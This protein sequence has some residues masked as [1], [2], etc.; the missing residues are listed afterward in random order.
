MKSLLARI[1]IC[2]LLVSATTALAASEEAV[3]RN[4]AGAKLTQQGKLDAAIDAFQQAIG[5]DPN[6][7]PARL[8]LAYAYDKANQMDEAIDA[9]R[10]AIET[11]PRSFFAH[12]NLGV[13]YDKKGL[14]DDAITEFEKALEIEPGNSS[15]RQNLEVAK[16]NKKI[17]DERAARIQ[18]AEQEARAKPNDAGASYNLARTYAFYGQ[19]ESAFEWLDKARK[20]GYKDLEYLKIDPAFESLRND[21]DFERLTTP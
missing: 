13:L 18:R 15:A 16:K 19:K 10:G 8:N 5:L 6:Y 12:N 21:P 9:Y 3:E 2:G 17:V 14:Y 1:A 20:Q 7:F 4:G 11:Q